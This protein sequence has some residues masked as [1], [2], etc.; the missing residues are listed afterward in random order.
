MVS[1]LETKSTVVSSYGTNSIQYLLLDD[2]KGR[3]T[4]EYDA[5]IRAFKRA[6]V[7]HNLLQKARQSMSTILNGDTIE[8][9]ENQLESIHSTLMG[10]LPMEVAD[11]VVN[12]NSNVSG[13]HG[14][15]GWM[16]L[17]LAV[18]RDTSNALEKYRRQSEQITI[19]IRSTASSAVLSLRHAATL[20]SSMSST[21]SIASSASG[22]AV[23]SNASYKCGI[24]IQSL[25][26][27]NF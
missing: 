24:Y 26:V 14:D 11:K 2:A 25:M 13:I 16:G 19:T 6:G 15:G 4:M 7:E 5:V 9:Q 20:P 23:L 18:R 27:K 22:V 1:M 21:S 12:G 8:K 3:I 17:L 10:S